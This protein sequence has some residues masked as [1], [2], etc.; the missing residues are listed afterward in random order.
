M[1]ATRAESAYDLVQFVIVG[2]AVLELSRVTEIVER[3]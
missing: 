2:D 3:A 1:S